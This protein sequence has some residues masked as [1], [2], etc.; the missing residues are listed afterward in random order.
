MVMP[1]GSRPSPRPCGAL[2]VTA[3][4]VAA[5]QVVGDRL[6]RGEAGAGHRVEVDAELVVDRDAGAGGLRRHAL[7]VGHAELEDEGAGL[8]RRA[9]DGA[10]ARVDRQPRGQAL[11]RPRVARTPPAALGW[12]L[13]CAAFAPVGGSWQSIVSGSGS[14]PVV[15]V[16]EVVGSGSP[17]LVG[18]DVV[19]S[20]SLVSELVGVLVPVVDVVGS[21]VGEAVG[22][23][24]PPTSSSLP[25]AVIHSGHSSSHCAALRVGPRPARDGSSDP[26]I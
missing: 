18:V 21:P 13:Y 26:N 2:H 12:W 25:Q 4:A 5:D 24:A 1:A 14:G 7:A 3:E 19:A 16:V 10:G 20:L 17:V 9:R 6:A 8:L 22:P 15:L 23:P 11:R